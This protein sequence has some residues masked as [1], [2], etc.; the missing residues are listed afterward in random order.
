MRRL[1]CVGELDSRGV[2]CN[3]WA[4]SRVLPLHPTCK[5]TQLHP[6][7]RLAYIWGDKGPGTQGVILQARPLQA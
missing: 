7:A 3:R 2:I 1:E 5:L 6:P 4:Q